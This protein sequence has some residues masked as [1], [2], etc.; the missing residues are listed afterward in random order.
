MDMDGPP[1]LLFSQERSPNCSWN[2]VE[3]KMWMKLCLCRPPGQLSLRPHILIP[4]F[5]VSRPM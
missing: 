5:V 1:G 4:D 2:L 3:W